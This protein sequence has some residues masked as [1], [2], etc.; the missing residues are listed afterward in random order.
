MDGTLVDN[1]V[2]IR[3]TAAEVL[4]EIGIAAPSVEKIRVTVG[5]SI[6]VTM[7]KLLSGTSREGE[8]EAVAARYLQVYP[9]HV[10]NGLKM[11]PYA[12]KIL[13]ALKGRGVKLA[14]FTNKQQEGAEE[15][16]G[17]L[18][19]SKYLDAIIATSLHSPR[20]PEREFTEH[21]LKTLSLCASETVGIGDSP[22][23]YKAA[24]VCKLASALVATG[25]D[26]AEF[27]RAQCPNAI[28]VYADFKELAK[29]VFDIAL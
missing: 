17:K 16:L 27:L 18:G 6:L 2:A 28:G 12:D 8:A 1:Y 25:G 20:K 4:G 26:S 7:R 14:C 24:D 19:L 11:M 15:I 21:A 22:Y 5:G 29:G 23:D 13:D 10:F 3:N 9:K